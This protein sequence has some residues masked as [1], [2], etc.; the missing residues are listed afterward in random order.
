MTMTIFCQHL[1]MLTVQDETP[2]TLS[3][4]NSL[5]KDTYEY[6]KFSNE[7]VQPYFDGIN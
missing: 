7:S 4:N 2:R 3:I 6:S 5:K 1:K